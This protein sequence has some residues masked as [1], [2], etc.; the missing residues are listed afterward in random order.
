[1]PEHKQSGEQDEY[2]YGGDVAQ[3]AADE[4]AGA[5]GDAHYQDDTQVDAALAQVA[6][7][8]RHG[9]QAA[10]KD[11][12]AAGDGGCYAKQEHHRQAY[13]AKRKADEPAQHAHRKRKRG[14]QRR[15]PSD[16]A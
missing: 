13:T 5:C 16:Y 14:E 4:G 7:R 2:A 1:M 15:L 8:A 11:V 12:C 10:H 6:Q 3:K 9:R